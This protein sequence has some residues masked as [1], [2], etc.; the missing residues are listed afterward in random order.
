MTF[1]LTLFAL[2]QLAQAA[3]SLDPAKI[4]SA[5][6][7][8]SPAIAAK[9]LGSYVVESKIVYES[10][11]ANDRSSPVMSNETEQKMKF[12]QLPEKDGVTRA[13]LL[14][15]KFISVSRVKLPGALKPFEMRQD[16]ATYLFDKP[17]TFVQKG[18]GAGTFVNIAA[19]RQA[20]E[21]SAADPIAR[22]G[23]KA[24]LS[25]EALAGVGEVANPGHGCFDGIAGKA[26]GAKWDF[27]RERNGVKFTFRCE[28]LGWSEEGGK[29]AEL[30]KFTMPKTKANRA[31]PN[32]AVGVVET[33]GTGTVAV[34]PKTGEIAVSLLNDVS[35][36]P[37]AAEIAQRKAKGQ[38]I[39]SGT[40]SLRSTTHFYP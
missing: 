5:K 24:A 25:D 1:T 22:Q 31:Q 35:A 39:P 13:E 33:S 10:F 28:F 38:D 27:S 23:L 20:A 19:V 3:P 6:D 29:G 14:Y 9:V 15:Q 32:G 17:L 40:G 4:P 11:A 8:K 7:T 21:K 34:D 36:E 2:G 26:P 37:T 12:T 16:L 30:V 18:S